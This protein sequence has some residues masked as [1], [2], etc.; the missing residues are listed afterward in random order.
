MQI[1]FAPDKDAANQAKHRVSLAF[2]AQVLADSNRLAVLDVRFDYAEERFVCY[3]RVEK[4]IWVC[5]FTQ[6]GDSRR[7][8]SV[9][10]AND[11]ET[12]RYHDTPR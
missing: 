7:I 8:I 11:R 5:V 2:G 6:R 3:G 4:R 9:R 12:H 10:K 1:E